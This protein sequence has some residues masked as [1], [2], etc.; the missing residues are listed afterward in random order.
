[1]KLK[2]RLAQIK[3]LECIVAIEAQC[4]SKE[5]AAERES[6]KSR[7]SQFPQHFFVLE[8]EETIIGFINGM[9]HDSKYITDE[10]YSHVELHKETGA[11]QTIF[12]LDICKK[13]RKKGYATLLMNAF[14]EQAKREKR[15][16][17]TLTCKQHLISFYEGF[18]YVCQGVSD[19]KHG[20]VIW[21]NMVYEFI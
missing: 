21:Y 20:G 9:V 11:W 3:D 6:I 17:C 13:H 1:M 19:S 15:K 18:G 8:L 7:L 16:G 12:G 10:M 4:F 5:E 14:I 2:I